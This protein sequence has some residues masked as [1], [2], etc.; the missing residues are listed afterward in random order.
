[1]RV[2]IIGLL[3]LMCGCGG[4][5]PG[6]DREFNPSTGL[7]DPLFLDVVSGA[8]PVGKRASERDGRCYSYPTEGT[9]TY[10]PNHFD[11]DL[12]LW[13]VRANTPNTMNYM[14][15]QVAADRTSA[16]IVPLLP[17]NGSEIV[18]LDFSNDR[19][20]TD[21]AAWYAIANYATGQWEMFPIT[22]GWQFTNIIVDVDPSWQIH[23]PNGWIYM[24]A[25]VYSNMGELNQTFV[26]FGGYYDMEIEP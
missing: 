26:Q 17:S 6:M 10:H 4:N 23:S 2:L 21:G 13:R 20:G 9:Y 12:H 16:P 19:Y 7:P 3:V 24:S 25:I 1:M 22:P 14:I 5:A 15:W 11:I 18:Q 8:P